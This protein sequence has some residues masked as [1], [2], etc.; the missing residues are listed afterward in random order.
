M[1]TVSGY[2][3]QVMLQQISCAAM[4]L[5]VS[6]CGECGFEMQQ[7][8]LVELNEPEQHPFRYTYVVQVIHHVVQSV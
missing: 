8:N 6:Q 7:A 3:S 5:M 2:A 4:T 1:T